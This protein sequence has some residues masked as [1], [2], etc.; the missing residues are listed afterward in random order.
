[1]GPV[2]PVMQALE[3]LHIEGRAVLHMMGRAD[4]AM[5]ALEETNILARVVPQ[6]MTQV[7]QDIQVRVGP[8]TMDLVDLHMMV[9]AVPAIRD[10]VVLVTQALAAQV[11][12]AHVC[13]D[14][15]HCT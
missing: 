6:T 2:V 8:R 10:Q 3:G 9:P 5:L 7:V 14:N 11:K 13:V 12:I 15:P 4:L 1:M